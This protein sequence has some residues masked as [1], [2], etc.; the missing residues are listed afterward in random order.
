LEGVAGDVT[1]DAGLGVDTLE[2]E[3]LEECDDLCGM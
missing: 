2:A 1:V 3:F